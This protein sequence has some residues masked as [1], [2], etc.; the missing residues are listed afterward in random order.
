MMCS[1]ERTL[2]KR[3]IALLQRLILFVVC[4]T[5]LA[6]C[7]RASEPE[8][9]FEDLPP[10]DAARGEELYNMSVDL[11]PACSNCHQ[12][13]DQD[14]GGPGLGG[15]AQIAGERVEGQSAEEYTYLAIVEPADYLTPGWSNVMYAR[16]GDRL[17]SQETADII[18][19]LLT[20]E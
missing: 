12:I 8:V 17:D 16:Y 9:A 5:F 18:A 14:V 15:Y 3:F 7:R 2:S 4:C 1:P 20:L 11:A 19:Y 13:D 10:G 6:A